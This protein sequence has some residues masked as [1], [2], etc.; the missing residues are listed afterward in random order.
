MR[1]LK[2][3]FNKD[4]LRVGYWEEYYPSGKLLSKGSYVNDFEVGLWEYYN[5]D[6]EL[7]FKG[8]MY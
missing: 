7:F 4:G 1:S 5:V 6:G 2:N 8:F 3:R